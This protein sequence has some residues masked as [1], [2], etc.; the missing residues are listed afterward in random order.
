MSDSADFERFGN[1]L[2]EG[3]S[4]MGAQL[5]VR[6]E[7][8]ERSK[9]AYGR[10]LDAHLGVMG[11]VGSLLKRR[12]KEPG[13]S[14]PEVSA[15]LPLIASFIQGVDITE[16]AISEGL[17]GQASALLRQELE[18]IAALEEVKLG[19]RRDGRTPNVKHVPWSLGQMYGALSSVAHVAK[20]DDLQSIYG[21]ARDGNAVPVSMV[22]QFN[23]VLARQLY[24]LHVALLSL[25]SFHLNRLFT[26]LY[27]SGM[28]QQELMCFLVASHVLEEE[29]FLGGN[30]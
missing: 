9:V 23:E 5:G 17:Y 14:S 16:T 25:A 8:R 6:L 27:G 28:N 19:R 18:T 24:S 1:M 12:N 26:E 13:T 21:M 22:A 15:A 10:L 11:A 7:I 29:G 3:P 2:R 4:L 30:G 20:L